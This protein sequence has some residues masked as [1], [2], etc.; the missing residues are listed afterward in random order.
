MC[1]LKK[2]HTSLR[3][4]AIGGGSPSKYSYFNSRSVEAW[5]RRKKWWSPRGKRESEHSF[6]PIQTHFDGIYNASATIV[7]VFR[8]LMRA[9]DMGERVG[10]AAVTLVARHPSWRT[11]RRACTTGAAPMPPHPHLP[12]AAQSPIAPD[13]AS[14]SAVNAMAQLTQ[15]RGN[16]LPRRPSSQVRWLTSKMQPDTAIIRGLFGV[17]YFRNSRRQLLRCCCTVRQHVP[18]SVRRCAALAR[19]ERAGRVRGG[20]VRMDLPSVCIRF[21]SHGRGRQDRFPAPS[22]PQRATPRPEAVI[23]AARPA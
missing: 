8:H 21:V 17:I 4:A 19:S 16:F 20:A 3:C 13:A 14:H 5:G 1:E 15:G 18:P 12:G 6:L 23:L 10:R 9:A 7:H 2:P 22:R 11:P